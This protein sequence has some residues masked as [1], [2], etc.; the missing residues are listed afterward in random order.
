MPYA[1][2]RVDGLRDLDRAFALFGKEEKK[3]FR[4]R[5]AEAAEPVRERAQELA[6]ENI[7]NIGS[8]WSEF[9]IGVTTKAVYIAPRHRRSGHASYVRPKF[10]GLLMYEAMSPALEENKTAVADNID[11]MLGELGDLWALA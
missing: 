6:D 1:G 8:E 7:T 5:L 3:K 2:V 11:S 9:R 4:V 10:G